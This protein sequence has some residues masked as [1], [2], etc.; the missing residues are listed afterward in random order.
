MDRGARLSELLLEPEPLLLGLLLS[1]LHSLLSLL[2]LFELLALLLLLLLLLTALFLLAGR[3]GAPEFLGFTGSLELLRFAGCHVSRRLRLGCG[4]FLVSLGTFCFTVCS[5]VFFT[6]AFARRL[7]RGAFT[8][9][10]LGPS[11]GSA[12]SA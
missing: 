7:S 4:C 6:A 3:P 9:E 1:S 8:G 12:P 11:S 2:L 5:F 10:A